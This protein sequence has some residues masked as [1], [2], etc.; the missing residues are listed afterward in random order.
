MVKLQNNKYLL[1]GIIFFINCCIFQKNRI[2]KQ[3]FDFYTKQEIKSNNFLNNKYYC[4]FIENNKIIKKAYYNKQKLYW[5]IKYNY[6]SNGKIKEIAFYNSKNQLIETT[7]GISIYK[8]RYNKKGKLIERIFFNRFKELAH[9]VSK[10][11]TTYDTKDRIK[12]IIFC[13]RENKLVNA[14]YDILFDEATCFDPTKSKQIAME[15]REYYSGNKLKK[16]IEYNSNMK[17]KTIKHFIYNS[18]GKLI[19]IKITDQK[20][21]LKKRQKI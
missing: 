9:P 8:F 10:A 12:K 4:I 2:E 14:W 5:I 18:K 20:G 16:V 15:E 13:N 3:C 19:E 11:L 17:I 1:W 7:F 21:D 6:Y